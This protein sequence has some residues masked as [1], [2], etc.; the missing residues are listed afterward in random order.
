MFPWIAEFERA[1]QLRDRIVELQQDIG[2]EVSLSETTS[3]SAQKK[4]NRRGKR[5]RSGRVPKPE[6]QRKQAQA[7][8]SS[9]SDR[10]HVTRRAA[11]V[12]R[13]EMDA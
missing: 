5:G 6:K 3:S 8:G 2:Q 13:L 7:H 1:A 11:F 4:K 12:T 9:W 10:T